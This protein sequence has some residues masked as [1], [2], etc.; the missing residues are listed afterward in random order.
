MIIHESLIQ[1]LAPDETYDDVFVHHFQHEIQF[2][3]SQKC[4]KRESIAPEKLTTT[5]ILLSENIIDVSDALYKSYLENTLQC[6]C[7]NYQMYYS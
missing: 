4:A 1:L 2:T 6:T 3:K 7:E 5:F